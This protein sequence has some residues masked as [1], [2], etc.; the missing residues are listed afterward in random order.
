MYCLTCD[1][2]NTY[3]LFVISFRMLSRLHEFCC[4]GKGCKHG[5]ITVCKHSTVAAR[6][7]A[8]LP[9]NLCQIRSY[10]DTFTVFRTVLRKWPYLIS[11]D[12]NRMPTK[13][14]KYVPVIFYGILKKRTE[15]NDLDKWE[16]NRLTIAIGYLLGL[17]VHGL[18]KCE[19]FL[20]CKSYPKK[21]AF[22]LKRFI[23]NK[24][25]L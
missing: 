25:M 14:R 11:I 24:R 12:C 10:S 22:T 3:S 9:W 6:K 13:G 21:N 7:Q 4:M 5:R 1:N 17:N 19:L 15:K 2:V 8:I 23:Y 20:M 16:Y 18:F